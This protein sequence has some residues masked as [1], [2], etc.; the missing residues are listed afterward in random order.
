[1]P[2]ASAF[3]VRRAT[4]DDLAALVAMWTPMQF[5]VVKLEKRLTEFQVAELADGR[6]VGAIGFQIIGRD[7]LVHHEAFADYAL[8]DPVRDAVWHRME[9]IAA[10]HGI[11]RVWTQEVAPFWDHNGFLPP[12]GEL[13]EKLPAGLDRQASWLAV[14]L[15][16][17]VQLAKPVVEAEFEQYLSTE[18]QKTERLAQKAKTLKIFVTI[19][20][21]LVFGSLL[22]WGLIYVLKMR[23][24]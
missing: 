15:R 5:D 16:E 9:K 19:L 21:V 22:V 7:A 13:V 14:Q 4:V 11:C 2:D 24:E 10:N 1:M 6:V 17:E 8:A 20:V 3:R 23:P 18:R 12:S